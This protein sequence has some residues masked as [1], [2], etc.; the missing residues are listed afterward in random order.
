MAFIANRNALFQHLPTL[1]FVCVCVCMCVCA[2]RYSI[3]YCIAE[4]IGKRKF[5]LLLEIG[6]LYSDECSQLT[7]K[8]T[9]Y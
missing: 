7:G 1:M 4:N 6:K 8:I 9:E 2:C 5:A 3:V